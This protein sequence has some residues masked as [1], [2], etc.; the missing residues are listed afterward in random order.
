MFGP[1]F[2]YDSNKMWN[3]KTIETLDETNPEIRKAETFVVINVVKENILIYIQYG[4]WSKIIRVMGW[5]LRV[6]FNLKARKLKGETRY[7]ALTVVELLKAE[8][9]LCK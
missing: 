4:N 8:K 6:Y 1:E 2:F 5:M 7:E 9:K 3:T